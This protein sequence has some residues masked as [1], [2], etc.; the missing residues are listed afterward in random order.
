ML[1]C[2]EADSLLVEL[3]KNSVRS[4]KKSAVDLDE[5]T[6]T[7]SAAAI[8]MAVDFNESLVESMDPAT[9]LNALKGDGV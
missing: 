2:A 1:A 3:N 4:T 6:T 8:T 9:L 7:A 5:A